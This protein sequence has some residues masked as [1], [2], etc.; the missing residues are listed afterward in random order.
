MARVGII[1]LCR[2]DSKRLPGKILKKIKG[3]TVLEYILERLKLVKLADDMIVAT[4]KE[5]NDDVIVQFCEKNKINVFRGDKDNVAKRMLDCAKTFRLDYFVRISGDNILI[6]YALID[7]LI[8]K[9]VKEKLNLVSNLP[10]RTFPSGISIE[11]VKTTFYERIYTKMKDA[12]DREH[13]TTY[14]YQNLRE[15]G[16]YEFIYNIHLAKAKDLKL[17]LDTQQDFDYLSKLISAMKK[18]H[19]KYL[20]EDVYRLTESL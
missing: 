6:D 12:Y 7:K 16:R 1:L 10:K 3:K 17:S 20:L 18:D 2:Y 5:K 11:V 4:S 15:I 8:Q 19:T 14:L 9:A 13:A